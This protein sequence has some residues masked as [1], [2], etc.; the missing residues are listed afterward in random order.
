MLDA[1]ETTSS[2]VP[3]DEV[4]VLDTINAHTLSS[5]ESSSQEQFHRIHKTRDFNVQ[6][7]N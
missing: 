1:R 2:E 6:D 7:I 3:E 5:Q 4:V